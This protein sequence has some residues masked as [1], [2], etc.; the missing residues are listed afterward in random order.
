MTVE[1][2]RVAERTLRPA[3]FEDFP[4][5]DAIREQLQIQLHA[6]K[7][8]GDALDHILLY[9]PPGLGKTSLAH[10]LARE[11]GVSIRETSGP[12]VERQ[13]DMVGLLSSLKEHD[14]FFIDEIH[15]LHPVLEEVLYPAME[16]FAIDVLVGQ[17]PG[18]RA[19]RVPLPRITIIGATTRFGALN[20]PFRARFGS[21]LRLDYYDTDALC[22]ILQR[23]ARVLDVKATEEGLEE[24]ARRS[25]GTPRIANRLLRRA[26]D[27]A[28]VRA[29]GTIDDLTAQTA[30]DFLGVDHSGLDEV[31]R[32]L[33][34]TLIYKF[35]GRPVGRDTL[36][37]AMSE[38]PET[39][40]DVYEPYLL[41]RGF[42][43]LTPRGRKP[44]P[45]AYRFLGLSPPE[46]VEQS[47]LF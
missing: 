24:I 21:T 33:L 31:D 11:M 32:E 3:S 46:Q 5:Q 12:A 26:R 25:R 36:A 42:I 30:L 14:I 2:D 17:G 44:T 39:I 9:G 1:E 38:A 40:E 15:R 47:K 8:R 13:G 19:I 35:D 28:E 10:V 29:S 16:D 43:E 18:A 7:Q 27:Y 20:A 23:S 37:A 34:R 45:H 4:G 41:Q 22:L 6:A